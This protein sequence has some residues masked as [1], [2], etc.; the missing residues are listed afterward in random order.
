MSNIEIIDNKLQAI[1]ETVLG[2][3]TDIF[4]LSLDDKYDDP[5]VER[6]SDNPLDVMPYL[7]N[8]DE[9]FFIKKVEI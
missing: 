8:N 9:I 3:E 2:N 6:L 5:Y 1:K 7:L 4:I